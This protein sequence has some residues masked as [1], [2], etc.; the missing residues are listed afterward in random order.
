A[1]RFLAS[2]FGPPGARM[3][4]TGD[5]ARW[6]AEGQL[7]FLGR[8]DDQVKIHGHRIELGE[9]ETVL[10][11]HPRVGEAVVIAATDR[12]VAYV[13]PANGEAP[14]TPGELRAF[15]ARSLPEYMVPSAFVLLD[16]MPL[17][18]NGKLDRRAL[19][20]PSTDS[21]ATADYVVPRTD[22][23]RVLADIWADALRVEQVGVE[24]SFFELGGD[25][26]RSLLITSRTKA[27]FDVTLTPRDVLTARTVSALA[28]LIEDKILLELEQVA[29]G[30]GNDHQR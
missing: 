19:P 8:A 20:A 26:V 3:Y 29:F 23:E 25:S 18:P 22:T 28:E 11:R 4:R 16:E 12:L 17:S 10:A 5:L 13:V 27:A 24:D 14:P 2:P 6:T 15:V 21:V 9:I 1:Q 30:D 7:D